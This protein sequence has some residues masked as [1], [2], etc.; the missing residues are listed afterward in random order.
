MNSRP[1]VTATTDM[2]ILPGV[3]GCSF[4]RLRTSSPCDVPFRYA[5]APIP[6]YRG[7]VY[8]WHAH[9]RGLATAI[10]E[11]YGLQNPWLR[12]GR[13]SRS[14]SLLLERAPP[15][16]LLPFESSCP[17]PERPDPTRLLYLRSSIPGRE[18]PFVYPARWLL[19]G[20]YPG[21]SRLPRVLQS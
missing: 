4:G 7:T 14:P 15:F 21:L 11:L 9:L 2:A 5:S 17:P 3:L 1:G 12:S 20:E 8:R 19:P 18:T 6:R 16:P 10:D 13:L